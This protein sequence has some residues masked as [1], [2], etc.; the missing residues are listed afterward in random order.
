MANITMKGSEEVQDASS[1]QY[2]GPKIQSD[3]FFYPRNKL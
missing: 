1:H 3:F 2:Q